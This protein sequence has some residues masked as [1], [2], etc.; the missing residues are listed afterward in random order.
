LKYNLA[1]HAGGRRFIQFYF[2]VFSKLLPVVKNIVE[3]EPELKSIHGNVIPNTEKRDVYVK[4]F[5]SP[6]DFKDN[7]ATI[8]TAL[9]PGYHPTPESY[10]YSSPG[11]KNMKEKDRFRHLYFSEVDITS[12]DYVDAFQFF[13]NNGI[14]Q[15]FVEKSVKETN[16]F[17]IRNYFD[18]ENMIYDKLN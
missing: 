8:I 10:M 1:F 11:I 15:V 4:C 9:L 14:Q 16:P 18:N 17:R 2:P 3:K 7:I 12:D 13:H 5:S 6:M